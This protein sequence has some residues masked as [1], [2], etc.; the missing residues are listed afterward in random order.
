MK[1][2]VLIVLALMA[3]LLVCA[4][5]A[6][7][8]ADPARKITGSV[9]FEAFGSRIWMVYTIHEVDPI[10][11]QAEGRIAWWMYNEAFGGWRRLEARADCVRFGEDIPGADPQAAVIAGEILSKEGWGPGEPGQWLRWWVR[12]GGTPSN[13]VDQW[14]SQL[15]GIFTDE[16]WPPEDMPTPACEYF[17]PGEAPHTPPQ[18]S[19]LANGNLAIHH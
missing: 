2:Q 16:F 1:K 3:V 13:G 14:A 10:T 12:D 11:H 17:V 19:D 8:A 15:H 6:P 7:V 5:P 18:P 4:A 9:N